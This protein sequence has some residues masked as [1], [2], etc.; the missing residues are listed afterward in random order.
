MLIADD[1]LLSGL[2]EEG[3]QDEGFEDI[4]EGEYTN[5]QGFRN[6]YN[7]IDRSSVSSNFSGINKNL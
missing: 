2:P 4:V 6:G 7:L 1:D 5:G 3:F